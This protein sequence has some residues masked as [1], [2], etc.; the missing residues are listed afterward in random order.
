MVPVTVSSVRQAR[1][2]LTAFF[3][4]ICKVWGSDYQ[5]TELMQHRGY[6]SLEMFETLK[7]IGVFKVDYLSEIYLAVPEVTE[8]QLKE[9]GLVNEAG[10]YILGGRYVV[11]IRDVSGKVTALVGWH[12]RGGSRKYVTTPTVGFSRDATFF[13]HDCYRLSWEKW[14][15]TVFLVEGIFDTI[16]LRS[17]GLPALGNQGLEMSA[18]KS[19]ILTRFGKVIAIPDNDKAGRSVNPLTNA[20][21]GK[22]SKF[23][24]RIEN[25]NVFVTL[26]AVEGVKDCDDFVK[27]YDAYDDLVSCQNARYVKKLKEDPDVEDAPLEELSEEEAQEIQLAAVAHDDFRDFE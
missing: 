21:S 16:A 1:E 9:W 26:P 20:L 25:D 3:N 7:S 27:L 10:D 15:G 14:K 12:P 22:S 19:Q 18:I 8:T 6:T 11:P 23:I 5:I 13:N 4:K 24:W 17:L 2:G